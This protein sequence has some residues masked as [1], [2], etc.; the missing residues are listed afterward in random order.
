M[1]TIKLKGND[2][3][4]SGEL[5]VIGSKAP[6]FRLVDGSLADRT[7]A[8]YA[9]KRVVVNIFP[10]VDTAVCATSVRRFN[11]KAAGLHNTVVLGVSRDLPFAFSRFCA[12]EGI[13]NV[14]T[15]S[16]MRQLKFGEDWGV[17]IVDGPMAGLLARAVVVL[18]ADHNVIY[19]QLVPEIT[20]EPDYE[21]ALS[22][23]AT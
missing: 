15:L 4:T 11:E 10:S 21:R 8:D 7:L 1:A 17:R 22:S 18:D 9:G 13:E 12:A 6:D 14:E 16:E 20:E 5:P 3:H 19:T 2:I 23:L